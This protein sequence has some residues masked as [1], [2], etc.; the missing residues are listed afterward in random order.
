[1]SFCY[2]YAPL[3]IERWIVDLGDMVDRLK[4]EMMALS[5]FLNRKRVAFEFSPLNVGLSSQ[6]R[7]QYFL[8]DFWWLEEREE[9][10][11]LRNLLLNR[12]K[13]HSYF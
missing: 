12:Q 5:L 2:E 9:E 3:R 6:M 11:R 7:I 13:I 8:Y 1:M 10:G 4:K